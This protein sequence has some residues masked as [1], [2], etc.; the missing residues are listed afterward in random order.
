LLLAEFAYTNSPQES[1]GMTPFIANK[2]YHHVIHL[3]IAKVE[4]T[5]ALEIVQDWRTLNK[6]LKKHLHQSFN[7]AALYYNNSRRETLKW[8]VGGKVYLN[9]TNIMTR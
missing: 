6:Y 5:K 7:Q 9:T 4:G 2:G 1:I 8:K 3:D